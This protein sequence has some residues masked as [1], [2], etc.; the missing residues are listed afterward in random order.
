MAI[1]KDMEAG[2]HGVI[3]LTKIRILRDYSEVEGDTPVAPGTVV[4]AYLPL[5]DEYIYTEG[6]AW[7]I[8]PDNGE[9]WMTFPGDYEVVSE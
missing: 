8:H 2:I 9:D 4:E 3:L 7:Y 1:S 6:E 5:T